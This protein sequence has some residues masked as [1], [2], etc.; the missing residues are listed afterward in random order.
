MLAPASSAS[1][2]LFAKDLIT[3]LHIEGGLIR[4][5]IGALLTPR[6]LTL[7]PI[8]CILGSALWVVVLFNGVGF[9]Y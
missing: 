7:L 2:P 9:M 6:H 3:W 5:Q 1:A 8:L 4:Q